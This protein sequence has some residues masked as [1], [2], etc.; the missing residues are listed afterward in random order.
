MGEATRDP[1]KQPACNVD[2][3]LADNSATSLSWSPPT[4]PNFLRAEFSVYQLLKVSKEKNLL[5]KLGK[6][7]NTT[8]NTDI[9]TEQ[10]TTEA[11]L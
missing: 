2:T 1:A 7:E 3:I 4:R 5:R 9:H 10:H 8:N 6:L 11:C